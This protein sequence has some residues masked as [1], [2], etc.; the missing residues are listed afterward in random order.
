[1]LQRQDNKRPPPSTNV[2]YF[3]GSD[4]SRLRCIISPRLECEWEGP[5]GDGGG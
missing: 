1:M 4:F 2:T 3:T 5:I